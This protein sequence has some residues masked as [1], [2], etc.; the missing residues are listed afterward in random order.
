MITITIEDMQRDFLTY[1]R[2]VRSGAR[3]VIVEA[4]RPVAEIKPFTEAADAREGADRESELK[5]LDAAID[6]LYVELRDLATQA[7]SRSRIEQKTA[8][9]RS[10]QDRAAELME[11]R[12]MTRLSF[13]RTEGDHILARATALLK[14]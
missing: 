11:E 5:R 3:L 8:E 13:D 2:E 7:D 1:F 4:N 10:L 12:A 9:L 14:R 6:D